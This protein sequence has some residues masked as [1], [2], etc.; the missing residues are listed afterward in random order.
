LT[1]IGFVVGVAEEREGPDDDEVKAERGE[2]SDEEGDAADD[3]V[4]LDRDQDELG[5]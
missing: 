1:P 3:V 2:V 5:R 4:A